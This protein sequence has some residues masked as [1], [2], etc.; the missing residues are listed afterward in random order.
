MT[1]TRADRVTASTALGLA[2]LALLAAS[3]TA[4]ADDL[5]WAVG[6][7]VIYHSADAGLSQIRSPSR[8]WLSVPWMERKKAPRSRLRSSSGTD[9]HT[10]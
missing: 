7:G 6:N 5:A 4:R 1:A 3:G 10:A 2:L 9:S 8:M